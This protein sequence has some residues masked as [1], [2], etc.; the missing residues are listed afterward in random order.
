MPVTLNEVFTRANN[1][2]DGAKSSAQ[3]YAS[4]FTIEGTREEVMR[5]HQEYKP[6]ISGLT[7]AQAAPGINAYAQEQWGPAAPAFTTKTNAIISA[8]ND[9]VNWI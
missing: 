5:V 7:N 6:L 8:A 1:S 9:V 4:R 3:V 2:I